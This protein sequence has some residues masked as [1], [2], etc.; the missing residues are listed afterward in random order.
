MKFLNNFFIIGLIATSSYAL[1]IDK[2]LELSYV[3]TS[4]N[5]NTTTF[6]SKLQGIAALSDT[7]SIKAKGS[8]LYSESDEN[9]SA[10]KYNVELDYNQMINEKLYSYMGINYIKDQLS[11]YDYRL[12]IGPGLG[13]KLLEDE[14][15]TIDIQG[16]LD[17][18]YDKYN[19][20]LKDNYLAGRTELNYKYTFSQSIEFKQM[21]SY[22]ASFEDS[23]KY[24]AISDST[25]GVKMTQN[26]SLGVSYNM[27]YT[28]K[29]EK[30]KLDTKFLTS[31]IV[32]F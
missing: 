31:L 32:D 17:Y 25:I 28:N 12:N 21:L 9:T 23:E 29:T 6:S 24:F 11:D 2:H 16:G 20:G 10:N 5:T 1:D 26:L 4:G 30:E 14:I 27:D 7:E 15:Q 18:A 19:D 22:L 8:I 3:Q 13:Y